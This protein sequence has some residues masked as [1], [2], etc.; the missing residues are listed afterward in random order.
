MKGKTVETKHIVFVF[1]EKDNYK[2]LGLE[3]LGLIKYQ[4]LFHEQR[5]DEDG[6]IVY[7]KRCGVLLTQFGY[8]F[9]DCLEH[10][11]K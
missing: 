5:K 4:Y 3:K 9:V 11:T 10:P 8:S 6:K 7:V 1:I 2:L